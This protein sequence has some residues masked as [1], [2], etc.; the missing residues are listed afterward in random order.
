MSRLN[1]KPT[2]SLSHKRDWESSWP[3]LDAITEAAISSKTLS[4]ALE[5]KYAETHRLHHRLHRLVKSLPL[6][7]LLY[8]QKGRILTFN[9]EA[10]TLMTGVD[11]KK[12]KWHVHDLWEC[13]G[14]PLVPF[15]C[16][17][18][19][20]GRLSCWD[21]PLDDP[22][23]PS[24]LSIRYLQH[25]AV[26]R[27]RE[28]ERTH[29]LATIGEKTGRLAHDIR[30]PLAS[31]EWFATLLGRDEQPALERR[32]LADH[33]IHAIRSLDGLV[34]NL[35]IFSTPLQ[36]QRQSVN[37][38]ALLDDV[39]LLAM[40]P[41]R[42]KRLIIHRHRESNLHEMTGNEQLLK[43]ALLNLLLNAIHASMPDGHIEIHCR[44]QSKSGTGATVAAEVDGIIL[45]IRDE[46][47]GMSEEDLQKAFQPFYSNRKGG[48]GLGLPIVKDIV[49]VHQ[50]MIDIISHK[51][52]GTTVE[53]FL[54]Q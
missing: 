5:A 1:P 9:Q 47:C 25:E 39:E 7:A 24:G 40:Y 2:V 21:C 19:E 34:S 48:T 36:G 51:G 11:W 30:N 49:H 38:S 15:T 43:Q 17:E 35:L 14:W 23:Q 33:L 12:A 20:G 3:S 18:W 10:R 54:P 41:L 52:K 29:R 6:P 42:K 28:S 31:I 53:L 27:K 50:G 22:D 46:G 8:N 37:L 45:S 32:E 26:S 16:W 44:R 4:M 13:L